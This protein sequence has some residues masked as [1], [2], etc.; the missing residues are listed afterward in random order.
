MGSTMR[1][2]IGRGRGN[3]RFSVWY[4]KA[5]LSASASQAGFDPDL[6]SPPHLQALSPPRWLFAFR[7]ATTTTTTRPPTSHLGATATRTT[8]GVDLFVWG[9]GEG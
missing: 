8:T 2:G 9:E 4:G 3:K 7:A 1:F 6:D 5:A